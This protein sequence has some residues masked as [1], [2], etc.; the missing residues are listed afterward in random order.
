MYDEVSSELVFHINGM[1]HEIQ[2]KNYSLTRVEYIEWYMKKKIFHM[3]GIYLPVI[4]WFL[5]KYRWIFE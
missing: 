5:K 3:G 2:K 4:S 1:L